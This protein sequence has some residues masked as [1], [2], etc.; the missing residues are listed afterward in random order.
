MT[1]MLQLRSFFTLTGVLESRFCCTLIIGSRRYSKRG[2]KQSL[3]TTAATRLGLKYSGMAQVGA[4]LTASVL[5][6][7]SPSAGALFGVDC[8]GVA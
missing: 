3:R 7:I 4:G 5:G 2:S 1:P 8:N 6:R